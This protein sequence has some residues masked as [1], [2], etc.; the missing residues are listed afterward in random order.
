MAVV[1]SDEIMGQACS[2]SPVY[3][4]LEEIISISKSVEDADLLLLATRALIQ[5][6]NVLS[7]V[8]RK[9]NVG[10]NSTHE[11][12]KTFIENG[13]YVSI[14]FKHV[15]DYREHYIDVSIFLNL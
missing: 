5:W 1:S 2:R 14:L 11:L 13:Y 15:L 10:N 12:K 4:I 9:E 7:N 6:T 3:I 8:L